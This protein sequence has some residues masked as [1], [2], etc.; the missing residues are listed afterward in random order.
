MMKRVTSLI[1]AALMALS[2]T[3][4]GSQSSSAAS[5]SAAGSSAAASAA[6]SVAATGAQPEG[7]PAGNIS[8]IVPAA[9][10][11]AI[12]LPARALIENLDLGG[13]VV[14]ENIAGAT[15]TIGSAEAAA[16]AA[17]GLT[18]LSG[19]NA[20]MLIKPSS[21]ELSYSI[22]SF[23]HIAMIAA[24]VHQVICTR[25]DSPFTTADEW[26]AYIT[27]GESYT[28]SHGSGAGGLGHLA[29]MQFLPALGSTTGEFIAYN[30]SAEMMAALLNGEIDWAICDADAA[31]SKSA[32]G[33]LIPLVDINEERAT[34][35]EDI[36]CMAD[37]GVTENM[38]LYVG[39]KWVAVAKDTPDD[40]VEYLKAQIN[41]AV[42]SDAYQEY[43]VS[44]GLGE[45]KETWTEE[46]ITD[47]LY[48]ARDAYHDMLESLGLAVN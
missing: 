9:A 36:P 10:G 28:Y 5:A 45:F 23:R 29:A 48:A 21:S 11:A 16:R 31:I 14:V 47:T 27:S 13:N 42:Q 1:L 39:W 8:W 18:L 12:D 41:A 33:E 26:L 37:L 7:Y 43:L 24:P 40:V 2:L 34:G 25:S 3:A 20:G 17:D 15:Q 46:E 44:S 4:C 30:G 35:L 22:E 19:S 6:A 32:S 38:N